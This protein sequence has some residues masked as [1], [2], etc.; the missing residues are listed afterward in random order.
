MAAGG[1]DGAQQIVSEGLWTGPG[2]EDRSE[3]SWEETQKGRAHLV[4]VIPDASVDPV[5]FE[6]AIA[7]KVTFPPSE[8]T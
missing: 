5:K 8:F 2:E 3:T 4:I 1:G 7:N 6:Q